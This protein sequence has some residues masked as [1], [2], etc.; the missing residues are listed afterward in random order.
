[1]LTNNLANINTPGFKADQSSIRAFPEMLL[2]QVRRMDAAG[3]KASA[4]YLSPVGTLNT[5]AYLQEVAPNFSQGDLQQTDLNTDIAFW[6]GS[7]PVNAEGLSGTVFFVLENPDGGL[8]YTRNGNFT[9]DEGGYLT[10]A[11][12]HYVLDETG[13]RIYLG[14]T[15]FTVREDGMVEQNGVPVARLGIAFSENP[16]ALVKR[17]EG[18]Y[19]AAEILPSAY[20]TAGVS[21]SVRQGYLERS[22]V[23]AAQ[24]MTELLSTYR[25]FEANQ[26]VLQAYDR[27]MELAAN[28]IGKV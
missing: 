5:G 11:S 22:N 17:G 24:T 9:V 25:N 23:D 10:T 13:N 20:N 16:Y 6:N 1:M 28:E 4:S 2:Q 12:G 15:D 19:E 14:G 21:F 3:G 26:K 27:S 18:L 8:R 7:M